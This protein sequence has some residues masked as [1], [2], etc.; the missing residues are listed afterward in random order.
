[1][2]TQHHGKTASATLPPPQWHTYSQ[3]LSTDSATE[4]LRSAGR[5]LRRHQGRLVQV[6]SLESLQHHKPISADV[7]NVAELHSHWNELL[8]L[9]APF[10]R[11]VVLV[12]DVPNVS[13]Q[14]RS[15]V[16]PQIGTI[17]CLHPGE[18]LPTA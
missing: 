15:A 10:R 16:H 11:Y 1:M 2:R 6:H 12:H 17:I 13:D 8:D 9:M 3:V 4:A 7:R 14:G 5:L 18:T